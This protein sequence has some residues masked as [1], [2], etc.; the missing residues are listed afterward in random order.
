MK[1]MVAYNGSDSSQ[2]ALELAMTQAKKDDAMI[3]VVTSMEGGAGETLEDI[4]R[5]EDGL[6][7][8]KQKLIDEKIECE[9]VQLARGLSPGEDVVKFAQ[10]NSIDHLFIGIEKKSRT[11]KILLGSTAQ[12]IILRGPC[13]VTTTK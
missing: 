10:D 5:A 11:R 8:V 6:R 4:Q 3:F 9:T 2:R 12:F 13:P 1:Y 7:E